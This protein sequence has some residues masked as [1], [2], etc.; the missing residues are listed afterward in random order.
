MEVGK[1]DE[2]PP[3]PISIQPVHVFRVPAL[4]PNLREIKIFLIDLLVVVFDFAHPFVQRNLSPKPK[5]AG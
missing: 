4:K 5:T 1:N 2:S 3:E